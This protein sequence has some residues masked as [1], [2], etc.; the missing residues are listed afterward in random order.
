MCRRCTW[1]LCAVLELGLILCVAALRGVAQDPNWQQTIPIQNPNY[2]PLGWNPPNTDAIIRSL[3]TSVPCDLSSILDQIGRRATEFAD[4]L[5]RFT[6]QESIDYKRFDRNGDL[7]ETH[8]GIFEY[9][10][11]FVD[12]NGGRSSTG[13]SASMLQV[14][15]YEGA[16][17]AGCW[18]SVGTAFSKLTSEILSFSAGNGYSRCGDSDAV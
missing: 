2:D 6:A 16:V 13:D 9:T 12:R 10:F 18:R 8:S 11:A 1:Q 15:R 5:E 14:Q 3:T 4:G 7:K 17:Y